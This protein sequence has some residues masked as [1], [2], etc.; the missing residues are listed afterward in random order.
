MA[1]RTPFGERQGE[2]LCVLDEQWPLNYAQVYGD[3]VVGDD[4]DQAVDVMRRTI[5][6]MAG[7]PMP[8]SKLPEIECMC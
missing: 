4:F 8:S 2:S 7:E 5:D 6:L 1:G 3:A